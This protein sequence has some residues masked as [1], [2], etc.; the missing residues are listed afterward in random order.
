MIL[1]IYTDGSCRPSNP[2]KC[3]AGVVILN[4]EN[5]V[6]HSISEYLGE[7]TNNIAELSSIKIALEWIIKNQEHYKISSWDSHNIYTDSNYAVG[8][9]TKNWNPK[10]NKELVKEVRGL[11]E[12]FPNTSISWVKAHNGNKYNE[13]ADQ[14]AN[15]AV[16]E[17]LDA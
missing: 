1:N 11:L 14:L 12:D 16:E 8:L 3:G 2:G 5:K 7:G 13:M 10:K 9:F 15:A 17:N 6:V 4:D